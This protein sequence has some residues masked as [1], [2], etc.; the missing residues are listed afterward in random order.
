MQTRV[1]ERIRRQL[2]SKKVFDNVFCVRDG[3]ERVRN[4]GHAV[5]YVKQIL[6]NRLDGSSNSRYC[7]WHPGH[8]R[9][10]YIQNQGIWVDPLNELFQLLQHTTRKIGRK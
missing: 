3:I 2:V 5:I 7:P 4:P 6:A 1:R 10:R 8:S 9:V